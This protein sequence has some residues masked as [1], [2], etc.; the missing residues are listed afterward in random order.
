MNED[1][2]CSRVRMMVIAVSDNICNISSSKSVQTLSDH[3]KL[4]SCSKDSVHTGLMFVLVILSD[5]SAPDRF[6]GALIVEYR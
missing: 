6:T 4:V 5:M 2:P 3:G 1:K